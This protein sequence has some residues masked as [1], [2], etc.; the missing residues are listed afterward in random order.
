MKK[1]IFLLVLTLSVAHAQE[2][3]AQALRRTSVD[4]T[5]KLYPD[6]LRDGS[7]LLASIDKI[8][9]FLKAKNSSLYRLPQ[10]PLI[11]AASAADI[12]KIQPNWGA[13]TDNEKQLAYYS[14]ADAITYSQDLMVPLSTTARVGETPFNPGSVEDASPTTANHHTMDDVAGSGGT[15]PSSSHNLDPNLHEGYVYFYNSLAN[16]S[17]IYLGKFQ[18]G[19]YEGMTP[20]QLVNYAQQKWG[21]MAHDDQQAYEQKAETYGPGP[22]PGAESDGNYNVNVTHDPNR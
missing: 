3:S 13:L 1:A 20:K 6:V 17:P 10:E 12:L 11:V 22:P 9:K 14:I 2:T 19:P 5:A 15:A 7:D 8:E 16:Q 18:S 21:S 4:I